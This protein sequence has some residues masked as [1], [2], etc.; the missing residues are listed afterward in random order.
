MSKK[1]TRQIVGLIIAVVILILLLN[2]NLLPF[3]P[4]ALRQGLSDLDAKYFGALLSNGLSVSLPRLLCLIAMIIMLWLLS[5]LIHFI[6]NHLTKATAHQQTVI[7]LVASIIKYALVIIGIIWGFVILGVDVTAMLASVGIIGLI[8][9]FGAQSLIEDIITGIFIILEGSFKVGDIIV[10]DDFRGTVRKIEVRTTTIEDDGGNLKV[11]NNSDIR[12]LQN[13]S[14]NDSYAVS[15]I[16]VS[17]DTDFDEAKKIINDGFESLAQ[18]MPGFFTEKPVCVGIQSF[19]D[20]GYVIRCWGIVKE[21]TVFKA[22]R[23]L[24]ETA[25]KALTAHG[26]VLGHWTLAAAKP[27]DAKKSGSAK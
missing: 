9:G 20:I 6:L 8:I 4:V 25:M 24:N 27:A 22:S 10:L 18:Q 5:V 16:T 7:G 26:V 17:Y 12:N 15:D 14:I 3:L 11:V 13:R 19:T 23:Y 2:P 1:N 21:N